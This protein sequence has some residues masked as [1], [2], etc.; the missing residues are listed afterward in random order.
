MDKLRAAVATEI[1]NTKEYYNALKWLSAHRFY[2]SESLSLEI[3]EIELDEV[4]AGKTRGLLEHTL[5]FQ[6]RQ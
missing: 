1:V 4:T 5:R 3:N 2:L 6:S